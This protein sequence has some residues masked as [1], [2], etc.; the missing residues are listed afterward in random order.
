MMKLKKTIL[1]VEDNDLNRAIL[2]EILSEEYEVLEAENGRQALEILGEH[3]DRIALIFLDVMMPVMDGYAFLDRVKEDSDMSLIPVIVTT[4]NESEADEVEALSHGATDF[5]PK[6]Y[7]PRVILHRAASLIKLRETSSTAN[8]LRFDRLTGLYSKDFFYQKV[9]E[10][11]LADPEGEYVIVCSNI[12]NFK[13]VNDVFGVHEGDRL[14]KEVASLTRRSVGEDGFCGRYSADRFLIFQLKSKEREDRLNFGKHGLSNFSHLMK[15]VV[16]R[17]GIYEITDRSVP[18]EQMCDRAMLAADSVKGQYR[19]FF[20]VYDE[21]M[22]EKLL[23]KQAITGAMET[24]LNEGQFV[25]YYQPKYD[26]RRGTIAGAEAL[27]RW[28]HPEWC[29]MSPGEFIP[30]FEKN[31]FISRLDQYI[32][33]WVCACL[34]NWREKGYPMIP[35]SVNVSRTDIYQLDLVDVFSRLTEEYGVDPGYL[36]LEITESAYTEN[37][38][39]IADTVKNLQSLGF[40]IEMDDF[41][42]GFS[43]LNMFSRM[44]ADILKLDMDF[45]R[46]ET[47][48]PVG[49]SILSDVIR[50]AHRMG[51]AVVAEGVEQKY[52]LDRLRDLECDFVQGY[53]FAKPMPVSE[54]ETLLRSSTIP[55]PSPHARLGGFALRKLVVA[56]EDA[57]YREKVCGLFQDDYEVTEVSSAAEALDRI[58][59]TEEGEI[60]ALILSST[61]PEN[62][63][64]VLLKTL[65]RNTAYWRIP[66]LILIPTPCEE[67]G[68]EFELAIGSDDFLCK[69]HPLTDLRRR[70]DRIIKMEDL[71][72]KKVVLQDEACRD[73]LTGLFNRRGLELSLASLNS[74]DLPLAV[75]MFDLDDLKGINDAFGHKAGDLVIRSFSELLVRETRNDDILCRYG[76]DEFIVILKNISDAKV[77]E[78]KGDGICVK[79]HESLDEEPFPVFCSGGIVICDSLETR[80]DDLIDRADHTM[81][82]AKRENKGRCCLLEDFA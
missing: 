12:E 79:F 25:I 57:E 14:L 36:H 3:K 77:I 44:R 2:S 7:R 32:W 13:F 71:Q 34:K 58:C 50:M 68:K 22:R 60:A 24:A 53:F 54:F 28:I 20:S 46:N 51:L 65:R 8:L 5:V 69:C 49:Q 19:Q 62:G 40:V 59:G 43:S 74:S 39:R 52:Q 45:I 64:E 35:V 31:G 55:L 41:G 80:V 21:S 63:A 37:P 82:R 16:L 73:P 70:V 4:Q 33:E 61:L 75:C 29:F 11:L 48:K 18:V 81:Y 10:Q 1:I 17:W 67:R 15:N 30:L 66:V 27:V 47:E 72:T 26:L 56:D 76:G 6:P 42:S 38:G 9:Q 23:R 78:K